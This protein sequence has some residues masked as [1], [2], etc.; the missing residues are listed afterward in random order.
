[1]L[2]HAGPRGWGAVP[3]GGPRGC[4]WRWVTQDVLEPTA[5]RARAGARWEARLLSRPAASGATRCI[6]LGICS[7]WSRGRLSAAGVG[8]RPARD[9]RAPGHTCS[10]CRTRGHRACRLL[11]RRTAR[12]C[13]HCPGR[14]A[15]PSARRLDL[16]TSGAGGPPCS[17]DEGDEGV[18]ELRAGQ[19]AF[20]PSPHPEPRLPARPPRQHLPLLR[21]KRARPGARLAGPEGR[22]QPY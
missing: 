5:T 21:W 7:A 4:C 13:P 14:P 12:A 10:R 17:T 1:M 20:G 16:A 8:A 9:S 19:G 3:G 11:G 6:I 18:L 2:P 22:A 15:G